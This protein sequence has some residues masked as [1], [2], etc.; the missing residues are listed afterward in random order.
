MYSENES[1]EQPTLSKCRHG[2]GSDYLSPPDCGDGVAQF[3]L[4]DLTKPQ[5]PSC[6]MQLDHVDD[7]VHDVHGGF[8]LALLD[9]L[10]LKGLRT[11]KFIPPKCDNTGKK[12]LLNA[13][14]FGVMP[15]DSLSFEGRLY[16]FFLYFNRSSSSSG[17]APYSDATLEDLKTKHLFKPAPSLPRTSE[18]YC[19]QG[20]VVLLISHFG[21]WFLDD[22][23]VRCWVVGE[24]EA[25][26]HAMYRLIEGRMAWYLDDGTI[27]G[28]TLVVGKWSK[29]IMLMDVVAKINDPQCELLLLRSCTGISKLY[30]SMRTCSPSVF[31]SAQR[32]FDVA[33]CSSLERITKL[34]RHTGIVS[35]GP[36]FDDAL[37]VFNTSLETNFLSNP[38][39]IVAPKLVK[40]MVDIYFT[41]VTK[42]AESSF[43]LSH[44]QMDLWT[45]QR[46]DHASDWLRTVPISG[47]GQTMNNK[48][49]RCVL[50][51][52]LGIPLFS[53]SKPCSTCSRVF[54]GDIYRD[55]A[56]SCAGI[57]GIKHRHNVVCDT[58]VDI[59]YRFGISAG[60]D[61][62]VDLTGSSPLA[63]TGMTDFVPGWAVIDAAQRK[64]CKYMDKCAA[65]GYGFLPFSFSS[66]GELEAD[67]ISLLKRIQ[68]F[69]MTQDIRARAAVHIFNRIGFSIAKGLLHQ[70]GGGDECGLTKTSL[71]THLHDR[72]CI[73]EAQAITKHSLLFDLVVYERVELTFKHMGLWLCGV[74]FRTHTLRSK[75]R[76]GNGSDY[77]SPPDC[78]DGVAQ[79]V[80]Y[81]LTKPQVPSCSMQLDHDD[82]GVHDL[83]GGFTLALLDTLFSKGLRTVKSIPLKCRLGFSR[84][85]KRALDKVICKPDDISCWVSLLV[86]PLCILKTFCPRSNLKC[87]SAIRRQRQEESI[88][89]AIRSWGMPGDSLQLLRETLTESSLTLSD[90]GD[91]DIDLGERNIKQCKRKISDGHYTAVVRVLSSS[92]VAP[93]SDATLEDLKTKNPF[94]P[95]PSLP[96]IPFDHHHLIASP[97]VVLDRIKSFPRGTSYGRYGLRAQHLIDCLSG[98]A[99]AIFDE[100]VSSITQVVNLFLGG[101]C[102]KMLGE[103][104]ASAPLTPLVKPGGGI[105]PIVFGV[106]VSG[107]SEAILHAMNRLIEGRMDDKFI[108]VVLLSR[109]G[110][111]FVT[112]TQ[113][114]CIAESTPYGRAKGCSKAWYLDDGTI[115]GDTLVVGKWSKTIMLMDVVAKIN[116]PQCELLLLRSCTGISKLYFSMRTCSPSVFESAQRSFDVALRSSLERIVTSSGPGFGD[117]QW[118]LATLP[119][120]FGG[121]GVYSAGDVLNYAFLA[122][123]LQSAGLQ[124]KLL[125][126]TGIVSSGPN[127]DDAL[128]VFNTSLETDFLS[129]P[130]EIAA[131]KLVKKMADIYFTWVTKNAESSFSL[132]PR[133]MALWTSQRED[134]AS[135]WLRTVPISGL[136]QTM[137]SKAYRC[138]LCYQL[139]IPLFSVSKPCSACSRVFAGD[140]YGDHVVSCA[141][142]IGIKH[143]H[144]VVCD[145][146]VDICYRFGISAGIDVCVDLTGSPPLAQTGMTDF[147]PGWA[148]IDAAQHKCGKYMDKCAAIR[149]GFLPFSF[150]SLGELEVDPISLLKRIQKFSMT[151]DIRARVAVRIFNRIGFSIAK[152]VGAQIVSRLPSNLL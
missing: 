29:T 14:R 145:T 131:P 135:N 64:R 78:G 91:E 119:F 112:L 75:C 45:S 37:R 147:V 85:L 126:H 12:L 27:V 63:Q 82:D 69:S 117:W 148:V 128:R 149:Y 54:A 150:S 39:E 86:L 22:S 88:V 68:K 72:L 123:R 70:S 47:L 23:T 57:I 137:N 4:Y 122:S 97:S 132:S 81:D 3:V 36:N 110:W 133:Q 127:F 15:G 111:N 120:A 32:S 92:G 143:R 140:I 6:S 84:V 114:D 49:Y 16:R 77:L 146:L 89:N 141:G 24:S 42:N 8:T 107:R 144:N 100:L 66:L 102:H 11:V 93:Y 139:G 20:V 136:G 51:Y 152:G 13:I 26:L 5:V 55:H 31:E 17:V 90:V 109:V 98:S 48:T 104:I 124:T 40:K 87:K 35:S 53:V 2:N 105:R 95:A 60:L 113:L 115:V 19:L 73:G 67:P 44:R 34:L 96:R 134:H 79:F 106:G 41:W 130:N 52:H 59:C 1:N 101:C 99:V 94:K 33:L 10:F 138:V 103:Y 125:R 129:N 116:D 108:S 25:L 65:I 28:D 18:A 121:L 118:R 43:S 151:Q 83:H 61:V 74:C 46:E 58:L 71:I 21:G 76:H 7:V 142:I 9:S 56:V 30:F 80:L 50:C 62:C 38:N